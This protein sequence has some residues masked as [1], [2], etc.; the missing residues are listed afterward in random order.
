MIDKFKKF[1]SEEIYNQL[2]YYKTANFN[3]PGYKGMR[4]HLTA[5][6]ED[7]EWV[8]RQICYFISSWNGYIYVNMNPDRDS[9][10]VEIREKIS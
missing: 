10:V 9:F 1:I 5:Y 6:C 3:A 2:C 4:F 7:Y 8:K